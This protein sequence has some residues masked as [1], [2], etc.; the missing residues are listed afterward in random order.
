M[1]VPAFPAQH[2]PLQGETIGILAG[3]GRYPVA[4]AEAVRRRGGRTAILAIR[5]HADAALEPLA[6][7]TGAWTQA[8]ANGAATS[9]SATIFEIR[10]GAGVWSST[11]A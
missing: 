3:W 11:S 10:P 2:D 9:R 1:T 6:F 8:Q 4:V 5:D 7:M